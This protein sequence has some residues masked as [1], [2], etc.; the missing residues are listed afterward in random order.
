LPGKASERTAIGAEI[1][2]GLHPQREEMPFL[3]ERKLG[4]GNVVASLRVAQEG[5]RTGAD[6]ISPAC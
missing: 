3:V 2:D 5:F 4:V 6:T 1:G